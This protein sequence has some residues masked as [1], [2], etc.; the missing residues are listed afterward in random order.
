MLCAVLNIPQP[1]TSFSIYNKTTGSVV[2]VVILSSMMQ[3]AREAV[4]ENEE[5]DPSHITAYF[6]GTWQKHGQTSLNGI[7]S[8]TS[9]DSGKV[10]GLELTSKSCFVCPHQ[11]NLPT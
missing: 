3:A 5:D 7:T 2:A 1:P 8:T 6:D 11:S 10:L 4:A 9:F